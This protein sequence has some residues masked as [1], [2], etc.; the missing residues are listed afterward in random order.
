M[1]QITVTTLPSIQAARDSVQGC[2]YEV[3]LQIR[4]ERAWLDKLQG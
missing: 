3:G 2:V 1:V 4:I